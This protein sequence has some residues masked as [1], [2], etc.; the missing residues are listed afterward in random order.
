MLTYTVFQIDKCNLENFAPFV[1]CGQNG[2]VG[3]IE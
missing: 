3:A 1:V 2:L